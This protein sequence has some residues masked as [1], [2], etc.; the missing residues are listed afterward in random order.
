VLAGIAGTADTRVC[1]RARRGMAVILPMCAVLVGA[2][3]VGARSFT[4]IAEWAATA[5]AAHPQSH[6]RRCR[7]GLS[8]RRSGHPGRAAPQLPER[9]ETNFRDCIRITSLTPPR[10]VSGNW[11]PPCATTG[12][13]RTA[14]A[15][16]AAPPTAKT[17]PRSAQ[18]TAP[19]LR[20]PCNLAI[21][22]LHLGGT[23]SM[24]VAS[25]TT[26]DVITGRF[27]PLVTK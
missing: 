19:A 25:A 16:P 10:P 18:P 13:S 12:R 4:A 22:I 14:F 3:L 23:T 24:A 7:A 11:P 26:A 27:K 2:R 21:S 17:S 1:R 5:R 15:G 8:P 9:Q 20:P 6:C